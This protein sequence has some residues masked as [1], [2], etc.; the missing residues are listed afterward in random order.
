[1]PRTHAERITSLEDRFEI[2]IIDIKEDIT[3]IKDTLAPMSLGWQEMTRRQGE[4]HK[5]FPKHVAML[6]ELEKAHC[7]NVKVMP[8][9]RASDG[10]GGY[11]ERRTK[12]GWRQKFR[13]MSFTEKLKVMMWGIPLVIIY[14]EWI[15]D[16]FHDAL[17][18]IE[19]LPK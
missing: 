17:N 13:E 8:D 7:P 12:K 16:K 19:A 18:W 2:T 5:V 6:D 11:I 9:K 3:E 15:F 4:H 10:N 14:W 1:M